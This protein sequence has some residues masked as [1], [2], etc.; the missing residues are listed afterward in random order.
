[1][2]TPSPSSPRRRRGFRETLARVLAVQLV[3]VALLFVL[4]YCYHTG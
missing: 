1:M 2:T 3:T 4:Q